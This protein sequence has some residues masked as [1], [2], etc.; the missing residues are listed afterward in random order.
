M[1]LI[2]N[3]DNNTWHLHMWVTENWQM[4]KEDVDGLLIHPRVYP[5]FST[6]MTYDMKEVPPMLHRGWQRPELL[7][8]CGRPRNRP[9]APFGAAC[10]VL[11]P[12]VCAG[13]MPVIRRIPFARL[14]RRAR[15]VCAADAAAKSLLAAVAITTTTCAPGFILGAQLCD[16]MLHL[17]VK[18]FY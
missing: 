16:A 13:D 3:Y 4:D 9:T 17:S 2:I 8:F 10:E 15:G 1:Q 5:D 18:N 6:T 12:V 11:G 7:L 14:A